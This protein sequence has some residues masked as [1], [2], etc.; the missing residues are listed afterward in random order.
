[1]VNR[2]EPP[3]SHTVLNR[4]AAEAELKQLPVV[5]DVVL[6]RRKIR[7]LEIRCPALSMYVVPNAGHLGHGAQHAYP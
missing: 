1:M 3:G 5:D 4:S 2:V 7:R 6:C